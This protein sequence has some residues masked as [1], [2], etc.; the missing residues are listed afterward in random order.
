MAV[1]PCTIWAPLS[2]PEDALL[3]PIMST[4]TRG[5]RRESGACSSLQSTCSVRSP[6]T[7]RF[8]AP[9][10][11]IR[12]CQMATPSL[13]QPCVM[14]SPTNTTGTGVVACCTRSSTSA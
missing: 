11:A 2:R 4:I 5:C 6:P 7:P 8:M 14:L 13:S 12:S 9:S 1:M 3:V 10:G